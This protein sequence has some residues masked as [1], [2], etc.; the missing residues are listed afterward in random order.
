MPKQKPKSPEEALI[1]NL[2]KAH[3]HFQRVADL[4]ALALKAT[5]NDKTDL[6]VKLLVETIKPTVKASQTVCHILMATQD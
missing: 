6:A 5:R 4:T 2:E 1:A 3:R